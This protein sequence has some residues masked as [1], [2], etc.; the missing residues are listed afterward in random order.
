MQIPSPRWIIALSAFLLPAL[1]VLVADV[2]GRFPATNRSALREFVEPVF[3][4]AILLAA[5]VSAVTIMTSRL[6]LYGRLC[7]AVGFWCALFIEVYLAFVW[8]LR[9]QH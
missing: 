1:V 7:L 9:G 6:P 8:A 2:L 5:I 4:G 3:V